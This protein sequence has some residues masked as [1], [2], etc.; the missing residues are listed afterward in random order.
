[1][2]AVAF[3]I[4]F[5]RQKIKTLRGNVFVINSLL[6][7]LFLTVPAIKEVDHNL[8]ISSSTELSHSF[9]PLL[10]ERKYELTEFSTG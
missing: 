8:L 7:S 10:I 1:M 4:I 2:L 9:D 3:F 6:E 5:K